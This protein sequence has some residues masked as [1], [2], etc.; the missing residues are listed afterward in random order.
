[1][2]PQHLGVHFRL[3]GVAGFVVQIDIVVDPKGG[4]HEDGEGEGAGG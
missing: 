4:E 3:G 1:M 2:I